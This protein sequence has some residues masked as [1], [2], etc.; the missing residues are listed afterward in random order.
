MKPWRLGDSVY[1]G[2]VGEMRRTQ[3]VAIAGVCENGNAQVKW[4]IRREGKKD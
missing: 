3:H 1:R 4:A 2:Q